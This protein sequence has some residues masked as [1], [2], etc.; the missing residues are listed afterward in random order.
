MAVLTYL[1]CI[2][3]SVDHPDLVHRML[4][5]L[6]ALAKG[7]IDETSSSRPAT[8][9]RR[10]K[11]ESLIRQ[12]ADS[13]EDISPGLFT[14]SDMIL[15]G[16]R[17]SSQQT[18]AATLRLLSTLLSTHHSY[19]ISGL[20]R[21]KQ[22][23]EKGVKRSIME[24]D[25]NIDTLLNMAEDLIDE[26][27][28][29]SY[30]K[31]LEDARTLLESHVCSVDLL[32]LPS[33]GVDGRK[34]TH[35]HHNYWPHQLA[36]HKIDT[37]DP[38]LHSMLSRLCQFFSNDVETNLALTQAISTLMSCGHT[39][40]DGW[41]LVNQR[42][43][44]IT[45][46][47]EVA[48]PPEAQRFPINNV[49]RTDEDRW[50]QRSYPRSEELAC[51][52]DVSP[53]FKALN[54]LVDQVKKFREQIQDFKIY[55]A[56]RKHVFK[57]GEEIETAMKDA[58]SLTNPRKDTKAISPSRNRPIG[59]ETSISERLLSEENSSNV[60]R[61]NSPRGRQYKG[62]S[63]PILTGRLS[64]LRVSPSSIAS[65]GSSAYSSSPLRRDSFSSTPSKAPRT[66]TG[67]ADAL[68]Q[69]IRVPLSATDSGNHSFHIGSSEVSSV[70]SES[71]ERERMDREKFIEVSLSQILTN[72]VIL[73]EFLLELAALVEVRASL[74]GEVTFT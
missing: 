20:I 61:A 14:L 7:P 23:K 11:S 17:S 26:D 28:E 74:F 4:H 67:P 68:R 42:G 66:P 9:A 46:S 51:S 21:T 45:S 69:R 73:Q 58:P 55:S 64:H 53:V 27:C 63:A 60:S 56:E 19:A 5:Y 10:R 59:Q 8:L 35:R 70:R 47:K 3:R 48:V 72:V 33:A 39:N 41:F 15:S 2:L 57:V 43:T 40:L 34:E 6:L 71:V 50:S 65:K 22:M 49:T 13:Q 52:A 16:I 18:V 1:R 12:Q 25:R 30:E 38:L 32:A 24:H 37:S 54:R 62:S 29:S 31:N 36:E 44:E